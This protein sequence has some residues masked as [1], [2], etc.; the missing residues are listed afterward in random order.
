MRKL[1][2]LLVVAIMLSGVGFA[3]SSS[4]FSDSFH[5]SDLTLEDIVA[6]IF[7]QVLNFF[8]GGV[9]GFIGYAGTSNA[10]LTI[11][12]DTDSVTKYIDEQVYF[13]ANFT[14]NTQPLDDT[15]ANVSVCINFPEKLCGNMSY[16]ST[17]KLWEVNINPFSYFGTFGW[18]VNATSVVE[19]LNTTDTVVLSNACLNVSRFNDYYS[20]KTSRV[21]CSGSHYLNFS[22]IL[23]NVASVGLDCNNSILIVNNSD[24]GI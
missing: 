14:N 17:S 21:I 24:L 5:Y 19:N 9:T 2:L 10:N 23:A 7:S 20:L 1:L 12:D 11:W 22:I 4:D 8:R 15:L 16:N 13:Y 3:I 6:D 18:S